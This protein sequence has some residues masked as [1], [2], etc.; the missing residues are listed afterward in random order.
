MNST[1]GNAVMRLQPA[2]IEAAVASG[3]THFY[4]PEF[5]V[6]LSLDAVAGKRFFRDKTAARSHL[7]AM[8]KEYKDFN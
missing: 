7:L 6:D 1:V 4:P 2:M 8:T 3:V 5:D